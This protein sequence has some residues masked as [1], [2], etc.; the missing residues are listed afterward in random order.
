MVKISKISIIDYKKEQALNNSLHLTMQQ[1]FEPF[2]YHR[3]Y[4]GV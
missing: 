2:E 1:R 3:P 4:Y